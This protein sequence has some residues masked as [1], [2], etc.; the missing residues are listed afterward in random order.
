MNREKVRP[1]RKYASIWIEIKRAG[2]CSIKLAANSDVLFRQVR[3][4]VIKE[5]FK[6]IAYKFEMDDRRLKLIVERVGGGIV[7]FRL[8]KSIGMEDV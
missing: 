4:G 2:E 6:D 1:V 8:V 7:K 5:K 3:N